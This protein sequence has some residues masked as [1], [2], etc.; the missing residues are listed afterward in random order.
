MTFITFIPCTSAEV[1][2]TFGAMPVCVRFDVP[3]MVYRVWDVDSAPLR[4][5]DPEAIGGY[6]IPL[7]LWERMVA[8]A[9]EAS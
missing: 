7:S 4:G 1:T 8:T 6:R 2:H 3:G 5:T 9:K